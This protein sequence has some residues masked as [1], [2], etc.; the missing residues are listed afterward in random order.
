MHVPLH[1][2]QPIHVYRERRQLRQ[3]KRKERSDGSTVR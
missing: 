1:P 3:S 2:Q